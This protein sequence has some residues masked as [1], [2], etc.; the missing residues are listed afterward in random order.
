MVL[1]FRQIVR[2]LVE[3]HS[4]NDFVIN[5]QKCGLICDR[6]KFI[7]H[8]LQVIDKKLKFR[9]YF[10]LLWRIAHTL[11]YIMSFI[12]F[13]KGNKDS[14]RWYFDVVQSRYMG[15]FKQFIYPIGIFLP[16][17]S[18]IIIKIF[19]FSPDN[20]YTWLKIFKKLQRYETLGHL[21]MWN[22]REMLPLIFKIKISLKLIPYIT[23]LIMLFQFLFSLILMVSVYN[24]VDFIL[25]GIPSMIIYQS[26]GYS[27]LYVTLHCVLCLFTVCEYCRLKFKSVN[28]MT[29]HLAK[30]CI[31]NTSKKL[32][33]LL[34]EHNSICDQIVAY[35][36]FWKNVLQGLIYPVLPLDLLVL[37]QLLFG[38]FENIFLPYLLL[39]VFLLS[40]GLLFSI[41]FLISLINKESNKSHKLLLKLK[42]R[43]KILKI[44][45]NI[46][47]SLIYS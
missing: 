39:L 32:N 13:I 28:K 5:I 19:N 6:N 3:M 41:I 12:S 27:I 29:E 4:I 46:K 23:V 21:G 10:H 7:E 1:N 25:Y 2:Q 34:E 9:K 22:K 37:H 43:L 24:L 38:K 26:L 20:T 35:N 30:N 36:K 8:H 42:Y 14:P 33:Q 44:S 47:V 16:L 31:G 11:Q 17:I 45:E 40:F 18:V 15:G